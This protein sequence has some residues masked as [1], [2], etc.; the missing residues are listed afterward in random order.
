M[1]MS[2]SENPSSHKRERRSSSS[3]ANLML[4]GFPLSKSARDA[5]IS[6]TKRFKCHFCERE[7]SNSQALGGHQNAH[8]RERRQATLAHFDNLSL[9]LLPLHP[10]RLQITSSLLAS[11]A[12]SGPSTHLVHHHQQQQAFW[13]EPEL[14]YG[15]RSDDREARDDAEKELSSEGSVQNGDDD[16]DLNLS[17]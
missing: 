7:F 11:S 13:S 17:L 6:F 10:R 2:A 14:W 3:S 12:P 9:H 1:N 16:V 8:K 5:S 15:V 4:F